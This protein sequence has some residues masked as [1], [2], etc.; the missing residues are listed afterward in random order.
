MASIAPA[1]L[2]LLMSCSGDA[3]DRCLEQL[4]ADDSV[5]LVDDGVTCLAGGAAR[6]APLQSRAARVYA[7]E[8]DVRARGLAAP[9]G[10]SLI[11]DTDWV[12]LVHRHEQSLSWT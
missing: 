12:R 10:V 6:L 7:L 3:F 1:R 8:A 5:L 11:G 9:A 4:G 2:H